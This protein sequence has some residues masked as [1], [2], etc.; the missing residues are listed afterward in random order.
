MDCLLQITA[1]ICLISPSEL[2][3]RADVSRQFSGDV[4][5][6][7]GGR[8]YGGATLAHLGLELPL[9]STSRFSV[10]LGYMH[11]SLLETRS[12]RGE[13]RMSLGLVWRP[14]K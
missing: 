5:H 8:N 13:E 9:I 10:N 2:T 4:T 12:D 7:S 6:W 11:E 1:A 3:L 14:F